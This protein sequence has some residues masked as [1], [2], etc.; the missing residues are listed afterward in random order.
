MR[1]CGLVYK[2]LMNF[3]EQIHLTIKIFRFWRSHADK[4][5]EREEELTRLRFKC[6]N[7]IQILAHIREKSAALD[8]DIEDLKEEMKVFETEHLIVSIPM[9]CIWE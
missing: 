5:E 3:F 9:T 4:I 7:T 2:M 8:V 6:Q 1:T